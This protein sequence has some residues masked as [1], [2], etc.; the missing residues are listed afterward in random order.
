M[1]FMSSV[2]LAAEARLDKRVHLM[3]KMIKGPDQLLKEGDDG[4]GKRV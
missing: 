3:S 2:G 4:C 1:I